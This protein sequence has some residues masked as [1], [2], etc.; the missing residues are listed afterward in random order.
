MSN[1]FTGTTSSI[2]SSKAQH[3]QIKAGHEGIWVESNNVSCPRIKLLLVMRSREVAAVWK[4]YAFNAF[5]SNKMLHDKW[6]QPTCFVNESQ[7]LIENMV[8]TLYLTWSVLIIRVKAVREMKMKLAESKRIEGY[9]DLLSMKK[10]H[11]FCSLIFQEYRVFPFFPADL[12]C[13][14]L[15]AKRL[16]NFASTIYI[17]DIN[18]Y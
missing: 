16:F 2:I 6:V 10:L 17:S 11:R 4:V 7:L 12:L 9:L 5:Y 1:W 13:D 3:T 18:V 15:L 8:D 14:S